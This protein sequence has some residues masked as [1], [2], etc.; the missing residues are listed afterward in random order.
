[1]GIVREVTG[2]GRHKVWVYHAYLDIL[3]KGPSP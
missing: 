1:M 2:K 3:I